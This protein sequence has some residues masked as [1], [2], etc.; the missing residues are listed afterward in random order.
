V[1]GVPRRGFETAIDLGTNEGYVGVTAL[2][3][4]G[5]PL[6]RSAVVAV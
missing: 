2:D 6:G 5:R 4:D 1:G 3:V